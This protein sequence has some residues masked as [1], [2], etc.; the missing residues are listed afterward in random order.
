M[1]E[2]YW[3]RRWWSNLPK[4]KEAAVAVIV[5]EAASAEATEVIVAEVDSEADAVLHE[6]ADSAADQVVDPVAVVVAA[7]A[8]N[9]ASVVTLPATV[10]VP[11]VVAAA[12][13]VVVVAVAATDVMTEVAVVA[14]ET[15]DAE[16]TGM[17]ILTQLIL[18]PQQSSFYNL[19]LISIFKIEIAQLDK[20]TMCLMWTIIF[21]LYNLTKCV[22]LKIFLFF[23]FLN[24]YSDFKKKLILLKI[25]NTEKNISNNIIF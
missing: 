21:L 16:E 12:A 6:E 1:A 20:Q 11:V 8:T 25:K 14:S 24:V 9:A 23:F 7:N 18:T 22:F 4:V 13:A 10:D 2:I 5:A 17:F 15:A 3:A 19:L